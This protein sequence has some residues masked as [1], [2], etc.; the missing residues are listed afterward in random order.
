M[1]ADD[2]SAEE[3]SRESFF[4]VSVPAGVTRS[5]K[6]KTVG[7]IRTCVTRTDQRRDFR[8]IGF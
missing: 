8:E 7:Q 6:Y 4:E 5:L 1:S 2:R 3:V